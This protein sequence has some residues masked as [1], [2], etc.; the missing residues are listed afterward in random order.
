[1]QEDR[2]VERIYKWKPINTR[3]LGRPKERQID[4]CFKGYKGTEYKKLACMYP[5]Q[6]Q[7]EVFCREGQ[8]FYEVVAPKEEERIKLVIYINYKSTKQK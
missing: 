1:M 6:K 7:M 5:R 4:R 2:L 3:K 8:N